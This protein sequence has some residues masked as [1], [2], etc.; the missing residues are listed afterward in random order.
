[1]DIRVVSDRSGAP[2][3]E[4][5]D[6]VK[7]YGA[8]A[9]EVRALTDVSLTVVPGEL[10]A[11]MGPSGCGKSTLLHLAGGLEDPTAGQVRVAGRDV[12]L[13]SASERASLRRTDVGYV[14]QRLNLV[15]SLTALENVMLPLELEG[16]RT[17][18]ARERAREALGAVG[19]TD[20]LDRFPDDFSGG[21]QQ[22]I[23]VARAIVG[24]RRLVL[25][26]EPTGALDTM[27]GDQVIELIAGLP[28][29]DGTAIVLV[30]HEPRYASW[31]DRVVF[32]RDGRV[33]DQ[34]AVDPPDV[35][36]SAFAPP[37]GGSGATMEITG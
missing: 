26:D 18:E 21:Q 1:M 3:L 35:D 4:L 14:F 33:V 8:G 6:V 17:R 9:T 16:V 23:A 15:V 27:T 28:G 30:T 34:S 36:H 22:R 13:M 2:A 32:L 25:A 29:R 24:Q 37:A 31:A 5:V 10:V 7:H 11:V 20:Q 12:P 19:L